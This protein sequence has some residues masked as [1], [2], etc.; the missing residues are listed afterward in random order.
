MILNIY[1][2]TFGNGTLHYALRPYGR[3]RASDNMETVFSRPV[4]YNFYLMLR[5][6]II[7]W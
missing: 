6:Y 4:A 5:I 2:K 1:I 3:F 7:I